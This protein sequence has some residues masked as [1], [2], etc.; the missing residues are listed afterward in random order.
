MSS[1]PHTISGASHRPHVFATLDGLRGVAAIAVVLHH[2]GLET[3]AAL[4][5]SAFVAVDFFFVLSGFVIAFA[6]EPRFAGGLQAG[7]FL[8]VRL[9]RLYPL[10]MLGCTISL[11]VIAAR[12]LLGLPHLEL[13]YALRSYVFSCLFLPT[14]PPEAGAAYSDA[15]FPLNGPAWSLS[16]ELGI[17]VLYALCWNRLGSGRLIAFVLLSAFGL[18]VAADRYA[19]LNLGWGWGQYWRLGTG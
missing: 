18:E 13:G 1:T 14:P 6:Y 5:H 15:V 2:Y 4:E 8:I 19:D 12:A 3:G 7:N 16:L 9:I 10:Y 17:N 11:A